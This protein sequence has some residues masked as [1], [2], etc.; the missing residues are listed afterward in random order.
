MSFA[1][2]SLRV[3]HFIHDLFIGLIPH[4]CVL[5]QDCSIHTCLVFISAAPEQAPACLPLTL[6]KRTAFLASLI[7]SRPLAHSSAHTRIHIWSAGLSQRSSPPSILVRPPQRT[8]FALQIPISAQV[9][10]SWRF[11]QGPSIRPNHNTRVPKFL[12]V[13]FA[14][15]SRH[16]SWVS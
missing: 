12:L 5:S 11:R 10:N 8:F 9:H 15:V 3:I 16:A 13:L 4:L 14:I 2:Y 1:C 6:G 7:H